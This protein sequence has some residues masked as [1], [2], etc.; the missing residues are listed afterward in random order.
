MK[1]SKNQDP[2]AQLPPYIVNQYDV[3]MPFSQSENWGITELKIKDLH[4]RGFTGKGVKIAILDTGVD[5]SHPDLNIKES[6]NFTKDDSTE[7]KVGHGTHVAGI[8]GALDNEQGVIGVA[9]DAEL[10]SYKVLADGTGNFNDIAEAIKDAADKGM[11][12]INMSLGAN[13][14]TDIPV[15]KKACKYAYDKG[16]ILMA[17]AGNTGGQD[18]IYPAKYEECYS[19][20][21]IDP[22]FR[23]S[24]FSS[25]GPHLDISAP[26]SKILSTYPG[27]KYVIMSGTSMA[28]PFATGCIALLLSAGVNLS[29]DTI[30]KSTIDI[31]DPAFDDL[32]GFGV[33]DPHILIDSLLPSTPDQGPSQ[34]PDQG[35]TLPTPPVDRWFKKIRKKIHKFFN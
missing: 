12:I 1:Q 3:I 14:P 32:S 6:Y 16:V 24:D 9:P 7:D 28:T 21:A 34:N 31:E 25:F 26:G 4:A 33:L 8:I 35:L 13:S 18:S 5:S 29:Y 11:H 17:A 10:Y 23:V 19:V 27:G 22:V 30:T 20:G 15:L 2:I